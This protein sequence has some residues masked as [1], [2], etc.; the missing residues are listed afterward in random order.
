MNAAILSAAVADYRPEAAAEQKIKRTEG[1]NLTLTLTPNP[2]IAAT[3]G[4]IKREG[5]LLIGFA[6]ETNNEESNALRKMVQKNLDYIVLNSLQD[7]GAGFGHDTNKVTIL[8][9]KGERISF[10]LK[11]KKEV[12]RDIIETILYPHSQGTG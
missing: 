7:E 12:A 3:L 4:S 6:L 9:R 5:Q 2:D 11:S 8:S 10:G 1:E